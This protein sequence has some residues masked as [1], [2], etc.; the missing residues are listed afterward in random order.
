MSFAGFGRKKNQ[1]QKES[2]LLAK[3][4]ADEH[5]RR[6]AQ[7]EEEQARKEV[8]EEEQ[9]MK[10]AAKR[11]RLEEQARKEAEEQARK[12]AEERKQLEEQGIVFDEVQQSSN[13]IALEQLKRFFE[14]HDGSGLF[15]SASPSDEEMAEFLGEISSS[16]VEEMLLE[17]YGESIFGAVDSMHL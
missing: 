10:E 2:E 8:E 15:G 12:E 6:D 13:E 3:E 17:E 16:E 5:A 11:K 7:R 4:A 14:T 1:A 9:A